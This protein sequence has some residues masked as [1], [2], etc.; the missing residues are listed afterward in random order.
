M[1]KIILFAAALLA[2]LSTYAGKKIVVSVGKFDSALSIDY[3]IE[4]QVKANVISG[5]NDVSYLQMIDA[6]DGLGADF[7]ITGSVLS[8]DVTKTKNEQGEL[9]Y[10]T[11]MSYSITATNMKDNSTTSETFKYNDEGFSMKYGFSKEETASKQKVFSFIPGDM[12][13]FASKNFPLSGQIV[14]ADYTVDKKGKLTECYIT[15]GS[16]DGVD[17]KTKF[18]VFLGKMIA[19]RT[20]QAKADVNLEVVEVVAGDL[21]RCKVSGK[22]ADKVAA[23]LEAYASNPQAAL[24]VIVKMKPKGDAKGWDKLF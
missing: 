8:Y 21:A 5:L 2:A 4:D 6:P 24:P 9:Y 11:R 7:L 19:G 22:E 15:L 20:T 23:A 12:K 13:V 1:K 10:K 14:E 16:D 3:D 17:A 18:D